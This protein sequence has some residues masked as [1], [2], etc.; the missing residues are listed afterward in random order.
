VPF[1]AGGRPPHIYGTIKGSGDECGARVEIIINDK[2]VEPEGEV[3][4]KTGFLETEYFCVER[5]GEVLN[6]LVTVW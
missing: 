1:C 5:S 4:I 3:G 6:L 2:Y